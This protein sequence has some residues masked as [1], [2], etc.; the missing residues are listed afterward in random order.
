MPGC[1]MIV[2]GT[3]YAKIVW[4]E[5]IDAVQG[6]RSS[7]IHGSSAPGSLC[8]RRVDTTGSYRYQTRE[9]VTSCAQNASK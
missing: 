5:N 9:D 4:D 7:V 1:K 3:M 2:Q 6:I 8:S